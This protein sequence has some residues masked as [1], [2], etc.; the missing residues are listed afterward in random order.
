M[1]SSRL[2]RA[3]ALCRAHGGEVTEGRGGG[4]GA[5]RE[6]FLRAPYLRDSFV[7]DGRPV[8]TFETAITWERLRA[9]V[10]QVKGATRAARGSATAL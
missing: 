5:W 4:S 3:L 8:E 7:G 10:E 1:P 2:D 6:A 9:F